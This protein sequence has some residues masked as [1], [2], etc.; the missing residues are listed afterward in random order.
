MWELKRANTDYEIK[1]SIK[2]K[3]YPYSSGMK[4]CDLCLQEKTTI[5]MANPKTTLNSRTE[6][7]AK[8]R[9]KRK[10]TLK[11][12]KRTYPPW[13]G[14]T[15]PVFLKISAI[16]RLLYIYVCTTDQ[17][18]RP[19]QARAQASECI[20]A[21]VLFTLSFLLMIASRHETICRENIVELWLN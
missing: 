13:G 5:A 7:L 12:C 18:A 20:A 3:A 8:C 17:L 9:H 21:F 2:C 14:K 10:Y 4:R 16:H 11:Y 19:A 1:W 6:I 15:K